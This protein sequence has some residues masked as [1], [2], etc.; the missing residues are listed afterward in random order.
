MPLLL[1]FFAGT[2]SMGRVFR[3]AGWEVYSVDIDPACNAMWTGDVREFDTATTRPDL[4]WASPVCTHYSRA[5]TNAKTPRD[6]EWADS[7]VAAALRIQAAY[8]C[9]MLFENPATGL[10]KTRQIVHGIP[11]VTLDYCMYGTAYRKRAAIWCVGC[12]FQPARPLCQKDCG[13]CIGNRHFERAQQGST[14]DC[15]TRRSLAQ[16]Y[17]IP[18]PLCEEIA[19]WAQNR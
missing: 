7:L 1:E 6:L 4:I 13:Q 19:R 15:L 8:G 12:T 3:Q 9:P 16:L 18:P 14:A 2:A 10:L 17:A 11:Y 5:R